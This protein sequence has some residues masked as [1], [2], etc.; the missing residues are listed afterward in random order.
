[1]RS[2][3]AII[4]IVAFF[5]LQYGRIVSY[6]H[7]RIVNTVT[8]TTACDCEKNYADTSSHNNSHDAAIHFAKEKSEETY[9]AAH[10]TACTPPVVIIISTHYTSYTFHL[11]TAPVAAIFHPPSC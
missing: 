1:M 11:P 4:C 9:C 5:A 3:T 10:T 6:W 2:L 7:C 8:T